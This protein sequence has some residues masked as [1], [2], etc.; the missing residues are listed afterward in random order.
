M[1]IQYEIRSLPIPIEFAEGIC[2]GELTFDVGIPAEMRLELR[3]HTLDKTP[4]ALWQFGFNMPFNALA[5]PGYPVGVGAIKFLYDEDALEIFFWD[6]DLGKYRRARIERLSI[7]YALTPF[8]D[9]TV[10]LYEQNEFIATTA[11]R[12][13][14]D[15]AIDQILEGN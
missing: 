11:V 5:V 3:R 14:V 13:A 9:Q 12:N 15:R 1:K 4:E 10:C 8:L 6:T 2:Y 7:E